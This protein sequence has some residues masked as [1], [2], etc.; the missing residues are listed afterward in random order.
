MS[1]AAETSESLVRQHAGYAKSLEPE[2]RHGPHAYLAPQLT[3]KGRSTVGPKGWEP[4]NRV[5]TSVS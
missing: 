5:L 4:Q 1:R 3:D 2:L